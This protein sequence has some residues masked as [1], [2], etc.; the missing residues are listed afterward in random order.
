MWGQEGAPLSRQE[1]PVGQGVLAPWVCACLF[2]RPHAP[3]A[4]W[5]ET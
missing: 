2:C 5:V 1:D 4:S 3:T